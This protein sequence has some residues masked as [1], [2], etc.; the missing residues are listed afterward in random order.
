MV[1][2]RFTADVIEPDDPCD[3]EEECTCT[4]VYDDY[5]EHG[6][7]NTMVSGWLDPSWSL[8]VVQDE[9]TEPVPLYID[10]DEDPAELIADAVTEVLGGIDHVEV[11]GRWSITAYAADP[12]LNYRTGES[13]HLAAHLER[14]PEHVMD[15]VI[16]RLKCYW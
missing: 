16:N 8:W 7:G 12:H 15:E 6:Y 13:A 10:N 5:T 14:V 9:P 3:N 1:T 11:N 4:D 2:L